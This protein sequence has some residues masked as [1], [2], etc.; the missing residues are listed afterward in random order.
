MIKNYIFDFGNVLARF[1]PEELTA[2]CVENE[3]DRGILQEVVFDR[4]YWNALDAGT[5]GD[6]EAKAA[7][8][9]RLPERLHAAACEIYDRWVENLVPVAGMP[10]VAADIKARGGKLY[11]LSNISIKF[12]KEYKNNPWI[13]DLF[14]LFDGLVLTGTIGI[15]KPGR[16]VFEHLL[17]RFDLRAE[18]CLFIDDT[19]RNIEGAAAV[20]I[21]G[22]RFD[23]D[24]E[25]LRRALPLLA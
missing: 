22:Y 5:M 10:A 8:C 1:Y 20:G 18:E 11:L 7:F 2:A 3:A 23:G 13:R 21:Q 16:E 19:V 25:A 12:S 17:T 14:A 6:D 9:S 4:L 15:V 24:A